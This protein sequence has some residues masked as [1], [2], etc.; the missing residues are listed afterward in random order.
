MSESNQ[1]HTSE[2]QFITAIQAQQ[3]K[4]A[5]LENKNTQMDQSQRWQ[6]RRNFLICHN[7]AKSLISS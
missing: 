7:I 3:E 1:R 4:I 5:H 2:A 6:K